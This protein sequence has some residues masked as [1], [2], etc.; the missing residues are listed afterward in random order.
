MKKQ[1]DENFVEI[2]DRVKRLWFVDHKAREV[3]R[4][5]EHSGDLEKYDPNGMAVISKTGVRFKAFKTFK[6][7]KLNLMYRDLDR[8][9][10]IWQ[11]YADKLLKL[12]EEMSKMKDDIEKLEGI[13]E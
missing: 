3:K 1:P 7:A 5:E 2:T 8:A 12:N 13:D 6:E 9:K 4:V 11:R 10:D